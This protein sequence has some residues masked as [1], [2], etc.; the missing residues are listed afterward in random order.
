MH[1]SSAETR[2]RRLPKPPLRRL[3][4]TWQDRSWRV[5]VLGQLPTRALSSPPAGV[6]TPDVET[7]RNQL[8]S[9]A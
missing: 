8:A 4:K 5:R 1:T 6:W 9:S 3:G 2:T 7:D